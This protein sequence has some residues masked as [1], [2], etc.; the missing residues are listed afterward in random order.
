MCTFLTNRFFFSKWEIMDSDAS[1]SLNPLPE[2]KSENKVL[3]WLEKSEQKMS[4][5]DKTYIG[6]E[7]TMLEQDID[8]IYPWDKPEW[9]SDTR[10]GQ[11]NKNSVS[12]LKSDTKNLNFDQTKKL[13]SKETNFYECSDA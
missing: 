12:S 1:E 13:L 7:S 2:M 6:S 8:Q 4:S 5:E 9:I 10:I 11:T 3:E